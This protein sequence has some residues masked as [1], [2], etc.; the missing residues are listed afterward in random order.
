MRR[1]HPGGEELGRPATSVFI[2]APLPFPIVE[3]DQIL[4]YLDFDPARSGDGAPRL[5]AAHQGAGIDDAGLP[6]FRD[7]AGERLGLRLADFRQRQFRTAAKAGR[8]DPIDV[9]VPGENEFICLSHHST[10]ACLPSAAYGLSALCPPRNHLAVVQKIAH[11]IQ[12]R[13]DDRRFVE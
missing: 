7:P 12:D 4:K 2:G 1:R 6:G 13:V 11:Q 8:I 10:M 5:N 3:I 9:P